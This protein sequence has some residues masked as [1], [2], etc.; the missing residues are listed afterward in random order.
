MPTDYGADRPGE[1]PDLEAGTGVELDPPT[2]CELMA[3]QARQ[4]W[5]RGAPGRGAQWV[6]R[7]EPVDAGESEVFCRAA[8]QQGPVAV[9]AQV[10]DFVV[11]GSSSPANRTACFAGSANRDWSL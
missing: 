8:G 11:L 1:E 9:K 5:V 7:A 3:R 6:S 4:F 2:F 10:G